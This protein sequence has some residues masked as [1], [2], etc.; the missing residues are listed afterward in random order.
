[1]FIVENH[2]R[3]EMQVVIFATNWR[4][5]GDSIVYDCL[6]GFCKEA[7]QKLFSVTRNSET[8]EKLC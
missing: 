2:L 6:N 7:H 1:M 5:L 3:T 8:A 4:H